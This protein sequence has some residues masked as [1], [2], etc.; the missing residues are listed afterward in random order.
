MNCY[1]DTSI[2]NKILDD[3]DKDLIIEDIKKKDII[4][5]PSLVNLCEILLTPDEKRKQRL[6]GIYHEIRNEYHALKPFTILLKDAV[7]TIQKGD[8]YVKVNMPVKIDA[9]TEQIC[10]DAL[11]DT[12]KEFDKYALNAREWLFEKRGFKNL[13]DSRTFFKNSNDERMN[14]TWLKRP[15]KI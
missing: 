4:A 6:L 11:K 3:Q 12:G 2:Y 15:L 5:I 13:L 9:E 14:Q 8:I 1:F 7:E 10:K